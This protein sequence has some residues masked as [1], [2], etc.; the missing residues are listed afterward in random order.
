MGLASFWLLKVGIA[1]A[2]VVDGNFRLKSI[3]FEKIMSGPRNTN[4]VWIWI[5]GAGLVL[6]AIYLSG[7]FIRKVYDVAVSFKPSSEDEK[8]IDHRKR[9]AAHFRQNMPDH[10]VIEEYGVE[11]SRADIVVGNDSKC[12]EASTEK[13]VIELKYKLK[14][15]AEID[16]LV[17]QCMHYKQSGYK[18][19]FLYVIETEP[20]ML[21]VLKNRLHIEPLNEFVG[22]LEG[23]NE[24]ALQGVKAVQSL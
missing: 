24:D 14:D 6:V 1:D 23:K 21:E 22:I 15:K 19:A 8:E 18:K 9:L 4:N 20:N 7:R 16:R 17:G 12:F 3:I 5:A 13:L 11:R 2:K 10:S